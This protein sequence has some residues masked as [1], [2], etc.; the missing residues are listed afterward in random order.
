MLVFHFTR[1]NDISAE[2]SG[3][4]WRVRVWSDLGDV[5]SVV[6]VC[7]SGHAKVPN[8]PIS[9]SVVDRMKPVECL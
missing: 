6:V 2:V 5:K 3:H 8:S 1:R 9:Q 7:D 4:M